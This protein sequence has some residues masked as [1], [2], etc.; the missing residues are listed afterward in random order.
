METPSYQ[1]AKDK[2]AIGRLHISIITLN[3]NGLNSPIKRHRVSEWIKK[4][5]PI[6]S[7]A[8]TSHLQRQYRLKVKGWKTIF[9]ANGILRKAGVAVLIL[10][11]IDF[12]IKKVKKD[13]SL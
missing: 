2:M 11:K 9:Q 10:D 6:I 12:K 4:Q 7:L 13:T 3:V 1:K 5:N 8:G